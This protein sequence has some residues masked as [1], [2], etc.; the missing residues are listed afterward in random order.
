MSVVRKQRIRVNSE[1]YG[2]Y[3]PITVKLIFTIYG[4]LMKYRNQQPAILHF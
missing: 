3:I 4:G 1:L 2:I